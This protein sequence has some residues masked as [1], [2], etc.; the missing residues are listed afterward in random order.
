MKRKKE[1]KNKSPNNQKLEWIL[2]VAL[3]GEFLGHGVFAIQLKA[4]F[5]EMLTAMT[6]ITG[7]LAKTLLATIGYLDIT[8]AFLALIFPFRLLLIWATL[9]GFLTALA[10]PIA[11]DPIWDF[12]ERWANWGIPLALLYVRG[13][14]KKFKDLF[15]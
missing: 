14:P 12:V 11:G 9:W 7:E 4:R 15:K 3:F 6:G 8:T 13:M 5:L 2:R 1:V 10:R